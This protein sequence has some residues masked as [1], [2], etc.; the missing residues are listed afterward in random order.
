MIEKIYKYI[1]VY[2]LFS[3]VSLLGKDDWYLL[4]F[5]I[6][7]YRFVL[8]LQ[9]PSSV[10]SAESQEVSDADLEKDEE[11]MRQSN[12][13]MEED[14]ENPFNITMCDEDSDGDD[15][16]NIV[17]KELEEQIAEN[18]VKARKILRKVSLSTRKGKPFE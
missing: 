16:V 15:F 4:M 10:P 1:F 6:V 5:N 8:K 13:A 17:V 12:N 11:T 18:D 3:F 2:V 14:V 9:R 7:I